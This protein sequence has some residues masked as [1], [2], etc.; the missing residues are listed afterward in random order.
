MF[1]EMRGIPDEAFDLEEQSVG[2][3][4]VVAQP[5]IIKKTTNIV[6]P[7]LKPATNNN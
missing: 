1:H 5:L 3:I 7:M 2:T 4:K 6:I